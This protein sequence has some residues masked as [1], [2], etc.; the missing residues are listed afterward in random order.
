M[1]QESELLALVKRTKAAWEKLSPEERARHEA[2]QRIGWLIGELG[3]ASAEGEISREGARS[4]LA[5]IRSALNGS[6]VAKDQLRMVLP[7]LNLLSDEDKQN[8]INC[9]DEISVKV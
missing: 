8:L 5:Q 9:I 1:A 6:Y 3:L 7:R 4:R 2:T